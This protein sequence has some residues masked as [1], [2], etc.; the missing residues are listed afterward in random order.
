M[1]TIFDHKGAVAWWLRPRT[2][3]PEVGREFELHS[4]RRV[5]SLSKTYLL[6]KRTGNTQEAVALFQHN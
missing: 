2:P 5:V 6:P 1:R 3:D 4:D